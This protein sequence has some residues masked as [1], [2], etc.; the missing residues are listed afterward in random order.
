[1]SVSETPPPLPTENS[2]SSSD[3]YLK[4]IWT[5]HFSEHCLVDRTLS[6]RVCACSVTQSRLTLC[7]AMDCSSPGF[8]VPGISQVRTLE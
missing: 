2:L 8:S 3:T 7:D 4:V 6:D 5:V 1:M